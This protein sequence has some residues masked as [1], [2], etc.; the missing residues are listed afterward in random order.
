MIEFPLP[1]LG[2]SAFSGTGKTTLLTRLLPILKRR[3]LRIAVVKHASHLFEIDHPRKDS[4]ELRKAGAS[5][6]LVSTR[7]RMALISESDARLPEPGL[8]QML[9]Y[10]DSSE[11]DL[12][13]VEGFKNEAIYKIELH[14]P[15]LGKPL[16][17][18]TDPFII[19]VA[20]DELV[21][22][23]PRS[24]SILNLNDP[25]A[26]TG[27]ILQYMQR[28]GENGFHEQPS[29]RLQRQLC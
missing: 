28:Y 6:M 8:G 19:A 14:R 16:L 21:P 15:A 27:F 18:H 10:L 26:I 2:F 3:G 13:L 11:L 25:Q 20:T 1:L 12:V 9:S 29:H 5:Q 22:A 17:C 23:I 7:G 24:L 4:Y